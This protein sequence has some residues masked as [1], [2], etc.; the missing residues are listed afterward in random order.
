MRR[1]V[2]VF[3]MCVVCSSWAS[4]APID[5]LSSRLKQY[6]DQD[7]ASQKTQQRGN[8]ANYPEDGAA[9]EEVY[10]G[11]QGW[12]DQGWGE[13]SCGCDGGCGGQSGCGG[14]CCVFRRLWGRAEYIAWWVRGSNTPPL[15]TTSP[16]D[17]PAGVAGVLPDA[18]ILFGD[19]RLNNLGRSGGRFTLGY[20]FNDCQTFGVENTFF[21]LGTANQAFQDSS[22]T[23]P[24]LGRPFFNTAT[25]NQDVIYVAFPGLTVGKVQVITSSKLLGNELNLRRALCVDA[26][27]RVDVLAGYRY[28]HLGEGLQMATNSTFTSSPPGSGI[29]VGTTIAAADSFLTRNDFNGGQLG[30]S[31]EYYDGCWSLETRVKLA[32]GNV[33]QRVDINGGTVTTVPSGGPTTSTGGILALPSNIG[34][35]HRNQF[36][37]VPEFGV[38]LNY[39]LNPCWKFSI[40]Y[41]IL[42]LTNVARPGDQIDTR[43]DPNQIPPPQSAGP[44]TFPTFAFHNSDILVQGIN[45][46]LEH[47]F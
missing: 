41:T 28:M 38:N 15:V 36:G 21:F 2:I 13:P 44:F 16:V 9:G 17:T 22:D 29:E 34:Q 7:S 1:S 47:S 39:Q 19:Q 33:S 30:F 25:G 32:I 24:I 18:T 10:P 31:T 11:D 45:L 26:C 20:W 35:Y 14:Q 42:A 8:S 37:V 46:G 3:A 40:G 23:T 5:Q 43:I 27:H 4:A 12:G 6:D